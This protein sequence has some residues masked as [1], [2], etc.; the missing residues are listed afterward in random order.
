MGIV[1]IVAFIFS[2][3]LFLPPC[4]V[5]LLGF[6]KLFGSEEAKEA[7]GNEPDAISIFVATL[8][9][10]LSLL[11][12]FLSSSSFLSPI[13]CSIAFLN[14]VAFNELWA[15]RKENWKNFWPLSLKN[16]FSFGKKAVIKQWSEFHPAEIREAQQISKQMLKMLKARKHRDQFK[17]IALKLQK[18][19]DREIPRLLAN[20]KL[21]VELT[22][23]AEETVTKEK[24]NGILDGEEQLM[25]E[26]ER[27]LQ[28]LKQRLAD[29]RNKI[30]L[31]LCF[32][33]HFSIRLSVLVSADTSAEAQQSLFDVQQDLDQMLKA[34]EE[35][36]EMHQ[37]YVQAEITAQKVAVAEVDQVAS[38]V[39]PPSKVATR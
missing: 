5:L 13:L 32:L 8:F 37:K 33:N 36:A 38:R 15:E 21:L 34:D 10:G 26:S 7:V 3:I 1:D 19:V 6:A 31:I 11:A 23:T 18:L 30:Q 29:T 4:I 17:A 25:K 35:I 22:A 14:Y 9:G 27:D 39:M 28:T 24:V 2:G 12:S 16:L 20:E